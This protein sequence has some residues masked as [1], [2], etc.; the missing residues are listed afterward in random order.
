LVD[1]GGALVAVLDLE[2]ATHGRFVYD[3]AVSATSWCWDGQAL[4]RDAIDA[5]LRAYQALRPLSAAEE[6][7]FADELRLA[8]ARFTITRITDVF[9]PENVDEDLRRRKDWRDYAARLIQLRG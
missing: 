5:M 4:R 8:S 2:Q 3:L 1:A 7:A 9:L 6:R